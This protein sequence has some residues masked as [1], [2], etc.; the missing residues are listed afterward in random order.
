MKAGDRGRRGERGAVKG[1]SF[2]SL[3]SFTLCVSLSVCV[4]GSEQKMSTD[5]IEGLYLSSLCIRNV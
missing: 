3:L 2:S 5:W 4:V 1:A